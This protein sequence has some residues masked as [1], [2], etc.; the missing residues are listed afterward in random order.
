L[1]GSEGLD[2]AVNVEPSQQEVEDPKEEE[3]EEEQVELF[4][5]EQPFITFQEG[6]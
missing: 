2:L 3:E 6:P 1:N 5:W 4:V